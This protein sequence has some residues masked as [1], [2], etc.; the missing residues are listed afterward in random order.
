MID[1]GN[2]R[3]N[4]CQ[5]DYPA[6]RL[7]LPI[8]VRG[9]LAATLLASLVACQ[10]T[11][12]PTTTP[13]PPATPLPIPTSWTPASTPTSE[14]PQTSL[15]SPMEEGKSLDVTLATDAGSYP[16][17]GAE[18]H[19][20]LTNNTPQPIYLPICG[21]WEIIH[22]GD[23]DRP[24]WGVECEID[25]LGYKVEPGQVFADRLSLELPP[26]SYQAQTMV[27]A[28]CTLGQPKTISA[29]ETYYGEFADCASWQGVTS[30][31]FDMSQAAEYREN[32]SDR[33]V[34]CGGIAGNELSES[35]PPA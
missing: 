31:S 24:T 1:K 28:D 27:Y 35:L 30:P 29:R 14:S 5:T 11:A 21:P 26:G 20:T 6:H 10:L 22:P 18:V 34:G 3:R 8:R 17:S 33:P 23:P 32:R 15:P 25:Y 2:R 7:S 13:P 4:R 12:R 16:A 9:L 19:L